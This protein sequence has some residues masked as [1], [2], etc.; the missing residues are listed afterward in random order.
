MLFGVK[1]GLIA[2]LSGHTSS[3]RTVSVLPD[4]KLVSGSRDR[5]VR[6]WQ[7]P[8]LNAKRRS[9]KSSSHHDLHSHK[10][11][12]NEFSN[13]GR[14]LGV[15]ESHE[16]NGVYSVCCLANG[17]VAV[18]SEDHCMQLWS[19]TWIETHPPQAPQATPTRQ[20]GK[21]TP[22]SP[23][24]PSVSTLAPVSNSASLSR[25]ASLN[26]GRRTIKS[27][28]ILFVFFF[29]AVSAS[30]DDGDSG[31]STSRSDRDRQPSSESHSRRSSCD[32]G[33][34]AVLMKSLLTGSAGKQSLFADEDEEES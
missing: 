32:S 11:D 9:S 5:S 13:G 2:S 4:G 20:T 7:L 15:I 23:L 31:P 18:S 30:G 17:N 22:S 27:S 21:R 26:L 12:H 1:T 14:C 19:L 3:V 24:S 28:V 25:P 10:D 16:N 33:Q 6:V 29:V 8:P 34:S